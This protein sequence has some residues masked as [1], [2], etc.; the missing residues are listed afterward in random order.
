M[1]R[2][3][4]RML[5]RQQDDDDI[6][7]FDDMEA[8]IDMN[9]FLKNISMLNK[10]NGKTGKRNTKRVS[11]G[12]K[13]LLMH[14]TPVKQKKRLRTKSK[15]AK[16]FE[17]REMDKSIGYTSRNNDMEKRLKG[18]YS[19][20]E[21]EIKT[22][23]QT[24]VSQRGNRNKY[25]KLY[26]RLTNYKLDI[27]K[28]IEAKRKNK[29][30]IEAKNT[31]FKPQIRKDKSVKRKSV[32]M[33]SEGYIMKKEE[34]LYLKQQISKLEE[35]VKYS[36]N[37]TFRPKINKD[38]AKETRSI[39][40]LYK[41]K[42]A[43]EQKKAKAMIRK[44]EQINRDCSF[45]PMINKNRVTK[46]QKQFK[47]AGER[48]YALH[49][50]KA[51]RKSRELSPSPYNQKKIR[52][53]SKYSTNTDED[54][55]GRSPQRSNKQNT[56]TKGNTH[57]NSLS[58]SKSRSKKPKT[59]KAF[60]SINIILDDETRIQSVYNKLHKLSKNQSRAS[61]LLKKSKREA[62]LI[63]KQREMEKNPRRYSELM[64]NIIVLTMLLKDK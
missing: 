27:E 26:S 59:K 23:G 6:G 17:R 25:D 55:C 33:D 4:S 36:K 48:L 46:G 13:S 11:S 58:K 57:I 38:T 1:K 35:D 30:E 20:V 42:E 44:E 41:W 40:D 22:K 37:C 24:P 5:L 15:S 12:M 21:N 9:V 19:Y 56:K 52:T 2:K 7:D 43:N 31:P 64:K 10:G 51:E 60:N 49:K 28:K 45:S 29:E 54:K 39:S 62:D 3:R 16:T 18:L 50:S 14:E 47:N 34:K 61:N 53:T 8:S 63:K 32:V